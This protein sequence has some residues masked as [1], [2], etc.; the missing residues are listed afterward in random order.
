[1]WSTA[2]NFASAGRWLAGD[3]FSNGWHAAA[4][5]STMYNHVAPPNWVGVDCGTGSA[6]PDVPGE[7]AVVSARSLHT[8]G[9]NV[10]FGDGSVTFVGNS[11]G[12]AVWR[13]MGTRNG[14]EAVS[15]T[16]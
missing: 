1:M 15:T 13:A 10:L 4:Y 7:H 14:G 9:V 5:A 8:G 12:L 6:I 11:V 16:H 2:F 3:D